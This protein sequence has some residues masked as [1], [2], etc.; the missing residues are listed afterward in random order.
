MICSVW[1]KTT[2]VT[3]GVGGAGEDPPTFKIRNRLG[4]CLRTENFE[5]KNYIPELDKY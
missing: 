1:S 3:G 4:K 2:L 5:R